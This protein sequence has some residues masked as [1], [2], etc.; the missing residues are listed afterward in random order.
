LSFVSSARCA[1]SA[2]LTCGRISHIRTITQPGAAPGARGP[3]SRIADQ[4]SVVIRVVVTG[5]LGPLKTSVSIPFSDPQE[6]SPRLASSA[7][8]NASF[9]IVA[10]VCKCRTL[11][12]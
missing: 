7:I 3:L 1:A 10:F 6:T 4:A 8:Y 12:T 9:A 5:A 2:A 11:I